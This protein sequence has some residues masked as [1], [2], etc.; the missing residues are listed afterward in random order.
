VIRKPY[1]DVQR[2]ADEVERDGLVMTFHAEHRPLQDYT[3]ALADL[4]FVIERMIEPTEPHP[5]DKWCRLPLFLDVL[6]RYEV[7]GRSVPD[8]DRRSASARS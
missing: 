1:Y 3:E 5:S 7:L 2:Y 6:C 8:L 4:G